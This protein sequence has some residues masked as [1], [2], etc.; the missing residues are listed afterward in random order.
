MSLLLV[1]L[2]G[3]A[4][5]QVAAESEDEQFQ[6]VEETKVSDGTG[7]I[8]GV[9]VDATITPIADARVRIASLD[10]DTLTNADGAFKFTGIDAGT[11]ILQVTALGY[12]PI[13]STATVEADEQNPAAIRIM[14]AADPEGT[15]YWVGYVFKGYIQ[16][17]TNI[18]AIC[19]GVR[20]FTG[21][22]DDTY[23]AMY[24]TG[25]NITHLQTEMV[26]SNTQT[27]GDAFSVSHRYGTQAQFDSGFYTGGLTS[28]E[29]PSPLKIVTP[30]EEYNAKEIGQ[31]EYK[32]MTSIFAGESD[33]VP[34]TGVALQ[35][36]YEMFIH[37]FHGYAPPEDW[38]F[39]ESEPPEPQA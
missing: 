31:G 26:W 3:C 27:L 24:D 39:T 14:L 9:V 25:A 22:G 34:L 10:A 6:D 35:Q 37:E 5:E 16:C 19:G 2:A 23:S 32:F 21:L 36:E 28:A 20:D 12:E 8:R 17:G 33:T 30:A 13:Q 38:R 7:V 15:P 1:G 18:I 4:D 29:G 11:Y